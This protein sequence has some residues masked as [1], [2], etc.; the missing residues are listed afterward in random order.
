[1]R[2]GKFAACAALVAAAVSPARAKEA[3]VYGP[4]PEW[5][6][7]KALAEA[8]LRA[9]LPEPDRW[10]VEW[11]N[12]Y[13][14]G[15]WRHKGSFRGYMSCGML[16]ASEPKAPPAGED[17][18]FR[19]PIL[20]PTKPDRRGHNLKLVMR[21]EKNR[22][23]KVNPTLIALLC[24]AEAAR[25]QLFAGG[26]PSLRDRKLERVARLAFLAPDIVSAIL[27]GRH[28]PSLTTRRMMQLPRIPFDWT[29]Q[30]QAL[31]F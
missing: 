13:V 14:P 16:R 18:G 5:S 19:I 4:R 24:K 8:A 22:P 28:P 2:Y 23:P 21:S 9:K 11:P 29:S 1:M 30:R 6:R 3:Y 27:E 25:A 26:E 20:I 7:Y 17:D 12:G 15:M 10:R 31:G